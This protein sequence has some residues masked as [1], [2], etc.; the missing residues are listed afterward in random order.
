MSY[1]DTPEKPLPEMRF[2]DKA[3]VAGAE[4][5]IVAVNGVGLR[6]KP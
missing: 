2:V 4:Y 6:S 1:H 5:R 3:P